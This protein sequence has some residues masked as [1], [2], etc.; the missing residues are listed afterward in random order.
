MRFY[1]QVSFPLAFTREELHHYK[2]HCKHFTGIFVRY[3]HFD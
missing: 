2:P 1:A 3:V